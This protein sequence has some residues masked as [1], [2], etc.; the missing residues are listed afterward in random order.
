MAEISENLNDNIPRS[1]SPGIPPRW[2]H[3]VFFRTHAPRLEALI[4]GRLSH[5]FQMRFDADDIVQSAFRSFFFRQNPVPVVSDMSL[6]ELQ[7]D[8]WPL[9]AEIAVRKLSQQVR[10]HSA[11]RRNVA[12]DV[13]GEHDVPSQ[14]VGPDE[15]ASLSEVIELAQNS[16]DEPSRQAFSMRLEGFE[17]LEIAERLEI[18]ERTVRRCLTSAKQILQRLLQVEPVPTIGN[19]IDSGSNSLPTHLRFEDYRL[20]QWI[21]DGAIG[22]VYRATEKSTGRTV[23]VK[24]LK[25]AFRS[26]HQ[27]VASFRHEVQIVAQLNHPGIIRIMGLGQAEHSGQRKQ[28]SSQPSGFT[29]QDG[30][31]LVMDWAPGGDLGRYTAGQRPSLSSI[32]R[33]ALELADAL[34]HAHQRGVVHCDLKPSNVLMSSAGRLL[35]SDFGLARQQIGWT[36]PGVAQGGT[37][38]FIAPELIDPYW[39]PVGPWTDVFGLGA[40]IFNLLSGRPLFEGGSLDEIL[41]KITG[42]DPISWPSSFEQTIPVNWRTL[43]DQLLVKQV[44]ARYPDMTSARNAILTLPA[45]D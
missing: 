22:N 34:Q 42:P 5:R 24:F 8:L 9:L 25:K 11:Q 23:A 40:I 37:P 36:V 27:A 10:R 20:H 4:R 3:S 15:A 19:T 1:Q 31:F 7:G 21:G 28:V 26:H 6:S 14:G 38:A 29:A 33:W 39:G 44:S 18:S 35:L 41:A 32:R 45:G 17:I 30:N 2:T 12:A 13:G 43:C 16:L